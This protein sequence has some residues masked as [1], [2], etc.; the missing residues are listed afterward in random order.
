MSLQEDQQI[1]RGYPDERMEEGIKKK[2]GRT[3]GG[4]K[5]AMR[6]EEETLQYLQHFHLSVS[7]HSST[8]SFIA[9]PFITNNIVRSF[10]EYET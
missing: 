9:V 4:V 7:P 6:E 1:D 10:H 2:G 8:S 3:M 5:Y